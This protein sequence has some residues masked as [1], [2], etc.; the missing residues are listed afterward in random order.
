MADRIALM[1]AGKIEQIG[2][3]SDLYERPASRF[4]ADFIGRTNFLEGV[5]K[6]GKVAIQHLGDFFGNGE[7][8]GNV[9][10]SIRPEW[11][12]LFDSRPVDYENSI[13][14]LVEEINYHGQGEN[15]MVRL[16]GQSNLIS[17]LKPVNEASPAHVSGGGK[18]WLA[19]NGRDARVLPR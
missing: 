6:G 4:V 11:I 9:T 12:R 17:V 2:S 8:D 5:A 1:R 19:W 7:F 15:I 10:Y 3:A 14:G 18:V 13:E 16:P